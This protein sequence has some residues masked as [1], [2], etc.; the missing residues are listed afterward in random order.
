ME[1]ECKRILFTRFFDP[2]TTGGQHLTGF[3]EHLSFSDYSEDLDILTNIVAKNIDA[4]LKNEYSL[5]YVSGRWCKYMHW[6][7][8]NKRF[9][10]DTE[11]Y[12]E[13]SA[14]L[15]SALLTAEGM[16]ELANVDWSILADSITKTMVYGQQ[17]ETTE[18]QDDKTIH[19]QERTDITNRY[20]STRADSTDTYGSTRADTTNNFDDTRTDE[21]SNYGNTRSDTTND[22]G[23][24][25]NETKNSRSAFN[26]TGYSAVDKSENDAN[27]HTDNITVTANAHTDSNVTTTAARTDSSVTT[28]NEH[29]DS[30]VTTTNEHTDTES[31]TV[32]Q[33]DVTNKYGNKTVTATTHTDTETTTG[34]KGFDRAKLFEI[35]KELARLNIYALMG[36]AIASVML[37]RDFGI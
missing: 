34:G 9:N 37:C 21:T 14:A 17:K 25:H 22:Y 5:R 16:F 7:K 15:C 23:L 27:A 18:R 29:T 28:E 24:T 2:Y 20:G 10:I 11:F 13:L 4:Y 30:N 3:Y 31:R 1:C 33:H 6:D 32:N 35:K 36:D 12:S 8:A 26:D 19:G